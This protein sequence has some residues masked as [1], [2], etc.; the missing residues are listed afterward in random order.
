MKV[1]FEI[2]A[3]MNQVPLEQAMAVYHAACNKNIDELFAALG[4]TRS[5]YNSALR[6]NVEVLETHRA[7]LIRRRNQ[8]KQH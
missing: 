6:A 3:P 1:P 4:W 8:L 7:A 2:M 5:E